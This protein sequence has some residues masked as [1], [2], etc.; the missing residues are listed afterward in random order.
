MASKAHKK[1]TVNLEHG[2]VSFQ[3][4]LTYRNETWEKA[5]LGDVCFTWKDER[6]GKEVTESLRFV[7]I[8]L[9][10]EIYGKLSCF[11]IE[12]PTE[13]WVGE[14]GTT[15]DAPELPGVSEEAG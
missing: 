5:R 2:N 12:A 3:S 1:V 10:R 7:D 14:K 15:T 6:S 11:H 9:I 13:P 8:D 4:Y